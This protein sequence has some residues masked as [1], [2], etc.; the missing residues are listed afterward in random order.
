MTRLAQ[1]APA[2]LRR[3][4]ILVVLGAGILFIAVVA[5]GLGDY[6]LNPPQVLHSLVVDDGFAHTVV[7]GWRL[8]RV[9]A[10]LA[11]GAALAVSGSFFQSLTGNPLGSPDVI[12]LGT[13]AYT[14]ALVATIV[15]GG[16]A[17]MGLGA[18]VGGLGTAAIVYLLAY[19]H[20]VAG[21]RLV[22]VG[23]GVTAMLAAVNRY[24]ILSAGLEVATSASIWGIGSLSLV[25][26]PVLVPALVAL[27]VL[28]VLAIPL[29]PVLRQLELGDD[30]ARSHGVR[31]EPD[32]LAIVAV[33]V[34][35]M[36]VVTAVAGPIAFVALA[37]PQI[38]ARLVRGSVSAL[39]PSAL[40]GAILLLVADQIAEHALPGDVPVGVVTV[41][42][43]GVYLLWL[44]TREVRR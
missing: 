11:F 1:L 25:R 39:V 41:G 10:A 34:G 38:S 12:G 32:R 27:A 33:G 29:A 37:A 20:G 7:A 2:T 42:V 21:F 16:G 24:L 23:I 13:G 9:V 15:V 19:R 5:L 4:R 28:A 40:T 3:R 18:I 31:V 44:L 43:G 30:T 6:P 17:S 36:S 26:W 22:I 14:G 8:P 35:L